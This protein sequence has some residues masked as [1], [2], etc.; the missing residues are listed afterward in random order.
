M[1]PTLTDDSS[2][3][4]DSLDGSSNKFWRRPS[5]EQFEDS[6]L[7]PEGKCLYMWF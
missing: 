2:A 4:T 6:S 1:S 5:E 3:R 7:E